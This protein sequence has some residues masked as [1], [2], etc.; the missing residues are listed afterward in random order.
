MLVNN[1]GAG[2]TAPLLDSDP[3][4]LEEMIQL[5]VTALVRLTHAA[6][7]M[8]VARGGGAIVNIAS[9]VGIAPEVL[10]G[11]YGASKAFVIAF[12]QSLHKEL[13]ERG[14]RVQAVLPG[15]VATELWELSGAPGGA[16]AAG[17]GHDRGRRAERYR[18]A[19]SPR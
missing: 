9:V 8:M 4:Q 18:G 19:E 10:N 17:D 7:T 6:A 14:V 15:A 13:G 11:V 12:T 5:N 16:P 1:A 2:A 3:E